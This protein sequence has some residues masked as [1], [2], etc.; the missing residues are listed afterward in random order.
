MLYITSIPKDFTPIH[1]GLIFCVESD[2]VAD[3]EIKILNAESQNVAGTKRFTAV[4]EAVIDIAPYITR[5]TAMR[6]PLIGSSRLEELPSDSYYIIA[7]DGQNSETSDVV[8]VSCNLDTPQQGVNT[9]MPL[10]RNIVYGEQD[11]VRLQAPILSTV[12]AEVVSDRGESLTLELLSGSGAVVLHLSTEDFSPLTKSLTVTL[13]FNDILNQSFT[14]S[15]IPQYGGSQRVAWVSQS[16]TIERY[17]FPVIES[18]ELT[19][20]RHAVTHSGN[21]KQTVRY[22]TK[23]TYTLNSECENTKTIESLSAIIAAERV[24]FENGGELTEVSVEQ[25][26]VVTHSFGKV[27]SVSLTFSEQREEVVP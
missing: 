11:D 20:N 10:P 27:G 17:T 26:S 16:G 21:L 24:W 7:T 19:V 23:R 25:N 6:Q 8:I 22:T 18:Q 1:R 9:V 2:D 14:Y 13:Y 5:F 4:T 15:I 12:V 3:L